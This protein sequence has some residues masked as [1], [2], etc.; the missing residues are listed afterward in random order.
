MDEELGK[1]LLDISKYI[2]TAYILAKMFGK[3]NDSI[4]A[5]VGAVVLAAASVCWWLVSVLKK[6]KI[7]KIRKENNMDTGLLIMYIFVAI[8]IVGSLVYSRL[9]DKKG[10]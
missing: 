1:W 7:K 9:E 2:I 5:V 8:I 10:K 6:A 4:L 3:D